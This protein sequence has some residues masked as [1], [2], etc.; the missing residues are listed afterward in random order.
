MRGW[1]SLTLLSLIGCAAKKPVNVHYAGCK[2][3]ATWTD[4][5]GNTR[6]DCD[7]RNGKQIGWDAKKGAAIIRC[8]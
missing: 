2:V 5:Q 7:C 8:E 4:D 6:K 1:I 3:T